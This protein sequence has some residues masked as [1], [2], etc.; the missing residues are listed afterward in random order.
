MTGPKK[1][2]LNWHCGKDGRNS[3]G[4]E[5]SFD[6]YIVTSCKGGVGKS[7]VAA[8]VAMAI[9]N[10]GTRVLV[11]DCDF[12]NRSLDLIFGCESRVVYD[13]CDLCLGRS[14]PQNT[15]ISDPRNENL[16]FIA[17]PAPRTPIPSADA[18]GAAVRAA[19]DEFSVDIVIIDT[20][21]AS[22]SVY[23][24]VAPSAD[25]ALIV[26]SH[27]PT[28]VRGAEATGYMLEG[29]G[30]KKQKLIINKFDAD[31]VL[32]GLRPGISELIDRTHVP[33]IGIVPD[34]ELLELA[35]ERGSLVLEVSGADE[36]CE[37]FEAIAMRLCGESVPLLGFMP[38]DKRKKVIYK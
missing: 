11:V 10:E 5:V 19:A 24:L 13:I 27:N 37:A 21:G 30:V 36:V 4:R 31:A 35:Q 15:V 6:T 9:A 2:S 1:T 38:K 33:L 17:G 18:F 14:I 29:L 28:T 20:P 7:S 26:T 34:S 12:S 23:E 3:Y 22:D 25:C 32:S 8:N 16:M